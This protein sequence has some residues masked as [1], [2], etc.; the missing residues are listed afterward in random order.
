MATQSK[1]TGANRRFWAV[2]GGR[3][4]QCHAQKRDILDARK[5]RATMSVGKGV[6]WPELA[7]GAVAVGLPNG[8]RGVAEG[9]FY[10][11]GCSAEGDPSPAFCLRAAS[12]E[13]MALMRAG[14]MHHGFRLGRGGRS[15]RNALDKPIENSAL[16]ALEAWPIF[17]QSSYSMCS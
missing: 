10:F 4:A 1:N 16:R 14:G 8:I 11:T 17:F 7:S 15:A 9:D 12:R 3:V 6:V 5:W 13:S 2:R